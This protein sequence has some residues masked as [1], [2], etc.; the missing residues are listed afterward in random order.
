VLDYIKCLLVKLLHDARREDFSHA[1]DESAG[2]KKADA[3]IPLRHAHLHTGDFKLLAKYA[4]RRIGTVK[5]HGLTRLY[6][7][8]APHAGD[9]RSFTVD[10]Q[11]GIS[12]ILT[13]VD[14]LDYNAFY[15]CQCCF[16]QLLTQNFR[17][18]GVLPGQVDIRT[19]EVT[20]SG[21]VLIN[22]TS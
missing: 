8:N 10:F 18:I 11:Y 12:A 21:D 1:L 9:E 2:Q 20:V 7:R 3:F 19:P 22:R 17:H 16:L 5:T 15:I 4:M 13:S 6:E 14:D